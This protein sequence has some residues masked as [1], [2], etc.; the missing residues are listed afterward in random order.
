MSSEVYV[1]ICQPDSSPRQ[2]S[3]SFYI[4]AAAETTASQHQNSDSEDSG[5]DLEDKLDGPQNADDTGTGSSDAEG[6][7]ASECDGATCRR[8]ATYYRHIVSHVE[9]TSPL[10]GFIT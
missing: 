3:L 4:T 7:N 1:E 5:C 2:Q 6:A 10:K 9:P 8:V